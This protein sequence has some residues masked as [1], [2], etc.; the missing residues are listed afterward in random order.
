MLRLASRKITGVPSMVIIGLGLGVVVIAFIP[1][2][3][4]CGHSPEA[5]RKAT[6]TTIAILSTV[7]DTFRA[8]N[9]RYPTSSEGLHVLVSDP[10]GSGPSLTGPGIPHDAWENPIQYLPIDDGRSFQ[11]ISA[12]PDGKLGTPDDIANR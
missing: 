12:G 6:Q 5:E 8:E 4:S 7:L 3:C 1:R 10:D 9:G 2:A 11:L